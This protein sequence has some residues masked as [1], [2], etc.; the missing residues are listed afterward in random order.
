MTMFTQLLI[1]GLVIG[2]I[3]GLIAVGYSLLY[4]ASGMLSFAQGDLLTV[5]AFVGW[6][7]FGRLKL[8]YAV[9]VAVV[10]IVM[11]IMGVIIERFVIRRLVDKKTLAIYIV[12]AT[13]A[14]SFILQNSSMVIWGTHMHS[15]PAV[16]SV[17]AIRILGVNVQ[18]SVL[19]VMAVSAVAMVGLHF[20]MNK[21]KF[22][23]AMRAA[24]M[25]PLA[26]RSCGIN[27][28]FTTGMTW[29]IAA[30]LAGIAGVIIGPMFGVFVM[31]GSTIG[32]KGFAGAV[33]GGYGNMYGAIVGGILLGL[34]ETFIAGYVSSAYRD[35]I[36]FSI[37]L[38]FLFVRPTGIFNESAIVD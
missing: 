10:A 23:T 31:L 14:I 29:G 8:P 25:D 1:S 13:I 35:L 16:F 6:T 2:C 28:S 4:K 11:F 32:S 36:A 30:A 12:L 19:L 5:G 34:L 37:L 9:A 22:G 15:Y 38:T 17:S 27:V 18:P 26:A 3:Y 33:M 21:T 7:L 24:T 20:F